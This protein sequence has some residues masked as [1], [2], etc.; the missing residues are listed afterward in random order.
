MQ[1]G[2]II[3]G[4]VNLNA[5]T[6]KKEGPSPV[7]EILACDGNADGEILILKCIR[8]SSKE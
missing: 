6:K 3:L 5:Y 4:R 7:I 2:E 1:E 8:T